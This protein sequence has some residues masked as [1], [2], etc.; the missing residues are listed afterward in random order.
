L[1]AVARISVSGVVI[2][3]IFEYSRWGIGS[4][5]EEIDRRPEVVRRMGFI[6]D[7]YRGSMLG[8]PANAAS[9][10]ARG[11]RSGKTTAE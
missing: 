4:I 6:R 3:K 5:G 8:D 10:P 9:Q 2:K 7:L 1:Q 11:W